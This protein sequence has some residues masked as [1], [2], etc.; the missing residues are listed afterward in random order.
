MPLPKKFVKIPILVVAGILIGILISNLFIFSSKTEE[1]KENNQTNQDSLFQYS[2]ISPEIPESV[3]FAGEKVPLEYFDVYESLDM[4]MLINTYRHS[5]TLLYIKRAQRYFP[6]IE[7]I[8]QQNGIPDDFKYLCIAESGLSNAISPSQAVGFWQFLKITAQEYKMEVNTNVDERYNVVISTQAA[9]AYL[10]KAYKIFN[11]WSLAAVSYNMGM[12]GLSQRLKHQK[13]SSYWDL[14]LH[15]EP[16][17]Y[18]YRIISLKI[19]MENPGKYGFNLTES[20]KYAPIPTKEITVDTSINRLQE[21]AISQGINYKM[22]KIFNPW[23]RDTMLINRSG[24]KYT[25]I[26][27]EPGTRVVAR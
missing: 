1:I 10:N 23:L 14:Y 16:A 17:R 8:L 7:E 5:S 9:C 18:V 24:K 21:F 22:L 27:P 6:V 19:I 20:D 11:N 15:E 25:L 26:I 2:V 4:E 12:A 13:V 3:Y